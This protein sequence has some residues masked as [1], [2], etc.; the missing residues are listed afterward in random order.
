MMDLFNYNDPI[1]DLVLNKTRKKKEKVYGPD[2][3]SFS[4]G[5]TSAYMTEQLLKNRTDEKYIIIFCNTGKENEA[6]L[7]FVHDCELRWKELYD[8]DVIWLEFTTSIPKSEGKRRVLW[9]EVNYFTADRKGNPFAELIAQKGYVPNIMA[10]FCTQELK[11]RTIKRYMVYLG[12]DYW[13]NIV[14]IRY[15]EPKRWSKTKNVSSKERFDTDMPMVKWKTTKPIV[16]AYWKTM[17]FDLEL[18]DYEGNCDFCFLKG[19]QKIMKLVR[20]GHKE[21]AMWW[22]EQERSIGGNFRSGYSYEQLINKVETSPELFD[23]DIP[24]V[25]C[26][27]NVD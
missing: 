14:G 22:V 18:E 26:F 10:R 12:Y 25:E 6:T 11:I 27:C 13:T 24:D 23:I 1:V 21:A 7:K 9:K 3:I 17:P 15:D 8:I 20:N 2:V 19:A 5:R 16:L 4:G